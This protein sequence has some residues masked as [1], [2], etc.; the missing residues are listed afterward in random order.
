MEDASVGVSSGE[1]AGDGEDEIDEFIKKHLDDDEEE[2]DATH[3]K[4]TAKAKQMLGENNMASGEDRESQ[5]MLEESLS[6]SEVS[7]SFD[8]E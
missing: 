2:P 1:P 4:L 6:D 3:E 7:G 5:D 8:S